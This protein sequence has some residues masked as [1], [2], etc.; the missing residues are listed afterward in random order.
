MKYL[1]ISILLLILGYFQILNPVRDIT[2]RVFAPFQFGLRSIALD[3]KEVSQLFTG[4]EK[5]RQEN[6]K[7][8]QENMNL[9]S[10]LV[11]L[12]STVEENDILRQQLGLKKE[13][14]KEL[15]MA[16]VMGNASDLTG[17]SFIIDRGSVDGVKVGDNIVR[18]NYLIGIV[19]E[20]G[21]Y[22]SVANFVSSSSVA[23]AALDV[24]V[25]GKTE[26]V[27]EGQYGSSII[28]RQI[29]PNEEIKV[30]DRIVTSGKDG[31]FVPGLLVGKVTELVEIPTETLK[32]VYLETFVELSKI[33]KVFVLTN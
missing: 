11:D 27:A 23:V 10:Q 1:Y 12:K 5:L 20:V 25:A 9:N 30:G 24:D 6:I 13:F 18:G 26:G 32:S 15:L 29:L 8:I 16:T 7:L 4:V 28:M 19:R 17:S 31:I 22:R 2:Q 3:I 21:A 14:K 33:R